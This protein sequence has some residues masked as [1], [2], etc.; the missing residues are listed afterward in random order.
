MLNKLAHDNE[1]FDAPLSAYSLG[2]LQTLLPVRRLG[3]IIGAYD[4]HIKS[5]SL[6][7]LR[8]VL[9][10]HVLYPVA[11]HDCCMLF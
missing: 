10:Q 3:V 6:V 7:H 9:L 2:R 11:Y 1:R 5:F 4:H 8:H